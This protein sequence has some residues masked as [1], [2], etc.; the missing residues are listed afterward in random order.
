M[1]AK[2]GRPE[3]VSITNT[4]IP[5]SSGPHTGSTLTPDFAFGKVTSDA[6]PQYS[7]IVES[8]LS[9]PLKDLEKTAEKH[10][11]RPEVACV[12]GLNFVTPSFN[13]PDP[14]PTSLPRLAFPDFRAAAK[15]SLRGGVE[16]RGV[17]WA[18]PI[19]RIEMI[20]W[21]KKQGTVSQ[22]LVSFFLH[23]LFKVPLRS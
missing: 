1:E 7:I 18:P 23:T 14:S 21:F 11:T 19:D 9:Q 8:A 20:I 4:P 2:R 15:V 6:G 13:Y 10:L 5:F 12:I 3:F 16:F 17:K 22:Y